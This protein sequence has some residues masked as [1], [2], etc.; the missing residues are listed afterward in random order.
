[1]R[2]ESVSEVARPGHEHPG[3]VGGFGREAMRAEHV[4]QLGAQRGD[5]VAPLGNAAEATSSGTAAATSP[6]TAQRGCLARTASANATSGASTYPAR[7][8]GQPNTFVSD[9]TTTAPRSAAPLVHV[10]VASG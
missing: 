9:P 6:F 10:P 2:G 4:D 5:G 1:M 7:R 8:P 3:R